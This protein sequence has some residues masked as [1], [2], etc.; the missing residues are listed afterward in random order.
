MSYL[1]SNYEQFQKDDLKLMSPMPCRAAAPF[2]THSSLHRLSCF[3]CVLPNCRLMYE[4]NLCSMFWMNVQDDIVTHA[5]NKWIHV[6]HNIR[7]VLFGILTSNFRAWQ[8]ASFASFLR[9]IAYVYGPKSVPHTEILRSLWY[10]LP[11]TRRNNAVI[12]CVHVWWL[13]LPCQRRLW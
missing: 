11:F 5:K 4:W 6:C 3:C 12:T 1:C 2:T 7:F 8:T 10:V 9:R 13:C